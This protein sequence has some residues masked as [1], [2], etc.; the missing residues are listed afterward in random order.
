MEILPLQPSCTLSV[1]SANVSAFTDLSSTGIDAG[2]AALHTQ[3]QPC[4]VP[5]EEGKDTA[6]LSTAVALPP[7][8]QLSG[9][10]MVTSTTLPVPL[11]S[12]YSVKCTSVD[13]VA[14]VLAPEESMA[15]SVV[16]H[17]P[18]CKAAVVAAASLAVSSLLTCSLVFTDT[19]LVPYRNL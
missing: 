11:V 17:W 2:L 9:R 7:P 5:F 8:S 13:E 10:L 14:S 18:V 1:P 15:T 4:P 3:V 16:H 12:G 19:V 6:S